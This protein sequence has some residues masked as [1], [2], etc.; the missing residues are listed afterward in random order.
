[1]ISSVKER[2]TDGEAS[3]AGGRVAD[4]DFTTVRFDQAAHDGEPEPRTAGAAIARCF[5]TDER[6]EQGFPLLDWNAGP[7][8]IDREAHGS[9][10][11][12]YL[13]VRGTPVLQS[14]ID[15]ICDDST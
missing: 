1:M 9:I 11:R 3:A 13:Y 7:F 4:V 12:I 8:I 5:Q 10:A 2:Q 15:Q 6:L 14:V